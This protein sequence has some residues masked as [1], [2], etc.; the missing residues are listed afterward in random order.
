[1]ALAHIIMLIHELLNKDTDIVTEEATLIVL[2][3]KSSMCMDKNEH[4]LSFIK[5][6][7]LTMEHMFQDQLLNKVKKVSTMQHALQEWL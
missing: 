2:D 7:Q 1:M 6:D 5:V 4:T 3:S